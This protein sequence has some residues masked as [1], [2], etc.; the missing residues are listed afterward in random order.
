MTELGKR[1][2]AGMEDALA[3]SR[4][5]GGRRR[6]RRVAVPEQVNVQAVRERLKMTQGEF[7]HTFGFTVHAV[8]NWEQGKRNPQG[9]ARVLL[10]VIARE[11]SAV[12]RAL[13][14]RAAA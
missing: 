12:V 13:A 8:R 1:I 11:P 7:A 2:L 3:F 14:I 10:T 4:G 9:A 5:E 6:V